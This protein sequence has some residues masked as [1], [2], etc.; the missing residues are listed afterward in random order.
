MPSPDIDNTIVENPY[1]QPFDVDDV[2]PEPSGIVP[3]DTLPEVEPPVDVDAPLGAN[4]SATSETITNGINNPAPQIEKKVITLSE[5]LF[6]LQ[7]LSINNFFSTDTDDSQEITEQKLF[8]REALT[9][10][11]SADNV[12]TSFAKLYAFDKFKGLDDDGL[13]KVYGIPVENFQSTIVFKPQIMIKF[14]EMFINPDD[15]PLRT[16]RLEKQLS[17]RIVKDIPSNETEL[18]A[19]SDK[20][21]NAF[22]GYKFTSS[23]EDTYTYRDKDNGYHFA[24]DATKEIAVEII[25]KIVE[26]VNDQLYDDSLLRRSDINRPATVQKEN[27]L[28][29]DVDMPLRGRYGEL[30]LYEIEYHQKGIKP[31][32]LIDKFTNGL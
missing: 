30:W 1:A 22:L 23:Y 14:R 28:G 10:D 21:K 11:P 2:T 16:Y 6:R 31:R 7:N 13:A 24:I 19:L 4:I 9:I 32:K 3:I 8:F 5:T 17:F 12:L 20:L 26:E 25:K 15:L 27:I 18:Q 29:V